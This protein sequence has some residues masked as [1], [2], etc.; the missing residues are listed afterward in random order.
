MQEK[1]SAKKK[2]KLELKNRKGVK[3]KWLKVE[4][5]DVL[6]DIEECEKHYLELLLN[7][8]CVFSEVIRIY[9]FKLLMM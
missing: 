5:I 7:Q 6:H 2:A 1:L 3:I 8:E 4:M 9:Q